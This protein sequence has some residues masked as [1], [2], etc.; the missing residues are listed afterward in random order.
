ML[1]ATAP[2]HALLGIAALV[3]TLT[4]LLLLLLVGSSVRPVWKF[5]AVVLAFASLLSGQA[6]LRAVL[7]LPTAQALPERFRIVGTHVLEPD[8]R[9]GE[10]G[11]ITFWVL[12]DPDQPLPRAH[13]VH[14]SLELHRKLDT[15]SRQRRTGA[16][17]LGRR[18][19]GGGVSVELSGRRLPVKDE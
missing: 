9:S 14:Y 15:L 13:A 18:D 10:N 8:P 19:R 3:L 7:G 17:L 4:V 2:D 11:M 6:S 12:S 1:F 16:S 5:A